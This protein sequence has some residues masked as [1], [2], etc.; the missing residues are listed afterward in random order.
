MF[1]EYNSYKFACSYKASAKKTVKSYS[2][3]LVHFV[4]VSKGLKCAMFAKFGV[5]PFA[6]S[7]Y[8]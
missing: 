5:S 7:V 3:G 2:I 6:W 4:K 8:M 1:T